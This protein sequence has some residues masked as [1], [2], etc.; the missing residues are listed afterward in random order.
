M[1]PAVS[2]AAMLS[3]EGRLYVD[4]PPP[5]CTRDRKPAEA[6]R[7]SSVNSASG[8][9][10][11]ETPSAAPDTPELKAALELSGTT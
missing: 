5:T 1:G 10:V 8:R 4:T 3:P 11:P 7:S 9:T 6:A 2:G